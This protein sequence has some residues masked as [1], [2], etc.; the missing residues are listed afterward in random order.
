MT[1]F[2]AVPGTVSGDSSQSPGKRVVVAV[3]NGEEIFKDDLY[4]SV[5]ARHES[6]DGQAA[7][8]RV[9]FEG[10]LQRAINTRLILQEARD[11]GLG[12]LSEIRDKVHRYSDQIIVQLLKR[13]KLADLEPDEDDIERL[14]RDKVRQW[15]FLAISFEDI[16]QAKAFHGE[17]ANGGEFDSIGEEYV[18]EGLAVWDGGEREVREADVAPE[19]SAAF[20][21]KEVGSVTPVIRAVNRFFIFKLTGVGYP[22]D[23]AARKSAAR[24]ALT[25][26]KEKVLR[27]YADLL[28]NKYVLIDQKVLATVSTGEFSDV[29]NDSRVLAEIDGEDPVLV[30]DLVHHLKGKFYHGDKSSDFGK[31]MQLNPKVSMK[32]V[33]DKRVF[34]KEALASGIGK[35]ERFLSLV[36]EYEN[37]LIFGM[38]LEKFLAPQARVPELEINA[39]YEARADEY[40]MPRTVIVDTLTFTNEDSARKALGRLKRG[41]DI[42]WLSANVK[43][44]KDDEVSRDELILDTLSEEV[45]TLF[46][47]LSTG[48][49]GLYNAA[50]DTFKVFIVRDIPPRKKETLDKVRSQI[51]RNLFNKRLNQVIEDLAA[52]LRELSEIKIY[53][54]KLDQGPLSQDQD[55]Q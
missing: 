31:A 20:L 19:I 15:K 27:E 33:L 6:I 3:V 43:G 54:E 39:A 32:E 51:T 18:Q 35:S 37:S 47:D 42:N 8:S 25:L 14:Y 17:L 44:L 12:E 50:K 28:I 24:Q 13:P 11:T 38:Y 40:L 46:A 7:P 1:F 21:E 29:G 53:Q 34:M 26:K 36:E 22:E 9:R 52:E 23:P 16:G 10:V 49:T 45:Q 4:A 2:A 55:G 48:D 5:A 41:A 30:S